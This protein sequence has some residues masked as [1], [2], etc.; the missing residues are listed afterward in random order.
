MEH[1]RDAFHWYGIGLPIYFLK[2]HQT[3]PAVEDLGYLN[4]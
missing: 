3:L 2:L 1:A 4:I